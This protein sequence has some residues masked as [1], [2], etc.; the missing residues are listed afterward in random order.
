VPDCASGPDPLL[1]ASTLL[2]VCHLLNSCATCSI[3]FDLELRQGP[4]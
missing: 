3:G 1:C 4:A 2:L